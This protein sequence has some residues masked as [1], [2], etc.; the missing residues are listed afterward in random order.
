MKL[1]TIKAILRLSDLRLPN[2][3]NRAILRLP[4]VRYEGSLVL[5][6]EGS[7]ESRE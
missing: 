1:S 4:L 2:Q 6:Y 7:A 5:S 3:G